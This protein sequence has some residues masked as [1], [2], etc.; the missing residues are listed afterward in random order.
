MII[1]I[2]RTATREELYDARLW[3]SDHL[4]LPMTSVSSEVAVAYVC[5][6]FEV[7]EMTSWDGFI[8]HRKI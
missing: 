1:T 7:A 8:D 3:T 5:Q 6:H 2:L 4:H